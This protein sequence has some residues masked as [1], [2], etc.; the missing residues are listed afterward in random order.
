MGRAFSKLLTFTFECWGVFE[1][2]GEGGD[3][4]LMRVE[5]GSEE[6]LN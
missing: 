5:W 3:D 4:G 1:G 6:L 2:M